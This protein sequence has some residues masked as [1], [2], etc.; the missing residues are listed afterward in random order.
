MNNAGLDWVLDNQVDE[1]MKCE[2]KNYVPFAAATAEK[3]EVP[4]NKGEVTCEEITIRFHR[5]LITIESKGDDPKDFKDFA[6]E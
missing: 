4:L 1:E 3:A 5:M 2:R 6:F